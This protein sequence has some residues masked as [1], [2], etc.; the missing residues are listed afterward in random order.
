MYILLLFG[1]LYYEHWRL[2]VVTLFH[3]ITSDLFSVLKK[4]LAR[5][6]VLVLVD[7]DVR[8][9]SCDGGPRRR[10]TGSP[11]AQTQVAQEAR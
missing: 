2:D 10:G 1:L 9:G 6:L 5:A 3:F 7:I 8:L 4:T 11:E